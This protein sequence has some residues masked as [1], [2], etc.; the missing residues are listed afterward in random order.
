LVHAELNAIIPASN[1]CLTSHSNQYLRDGNLFI[2]PI[3]KLCSLAKLYSSLSS[4]VYL[5]VEAN[6]DIMVEGD[7]EEG[8]S[9]IFSQ[10]MISVNL[11]PKVQDLPSIALITIAE[12]PK[13][14][15][16]LTL[17]SLTRRRPCND[18]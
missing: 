2:T 10:A 6:F 4:L 17:A 5:H 1:L 3:F 11:L 12:S 8:L 9:F 16:S 13:T 14:N 7:F 18:G 15:N